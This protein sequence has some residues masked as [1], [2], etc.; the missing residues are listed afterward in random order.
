MSINTKVPK[1]T[2]HFPL[3][4]NFEIFRFNGKTKEELIGSKTPVAC[5]P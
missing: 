3:K 5:R 2:F 1:M 4:S